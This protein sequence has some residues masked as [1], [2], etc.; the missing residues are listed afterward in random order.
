MKLLF[1]LLFKLMMPFTSFM[2]FY[3]SLG[4][5]DDIAYLKEWLIIVLYLAAC[6]FYFMIQTIEDAI[7]LYKK[8]KI[9]KTTTS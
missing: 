6:I 3:I 2:M 1:K 8:M 5:I 7:T 4:I 9:N